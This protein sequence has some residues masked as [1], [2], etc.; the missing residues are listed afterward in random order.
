MK[1]GGHLDR[2]FLLGQDG[3]GA[4]ANLVAAADN[5]RHILKSIAFCCAYI[6]A[7]IRKGEAKTA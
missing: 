7:T 2:N 5:L 1:I 6:I 4:N 3:D